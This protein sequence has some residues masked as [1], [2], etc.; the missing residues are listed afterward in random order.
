[1]ESNKAILHYNMY[2]YPYQRR[3]AWL[4][5]NLGVKHLIPLAGLKPLKRNHLKPVRVFEIVSTLQY[6]CFRLQLP[7]AR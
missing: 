4:D 6:N 3:T 5:D 7:M 2:R 1:M